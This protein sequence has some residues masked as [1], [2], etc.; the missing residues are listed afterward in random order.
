[1]TALPLHHKNKKKFSLLLLLNVPN[2][3]DIYSSVTMDTPV[4]CFF[5]S[6]PGF[7]Y[8]YSFYQHTAPGVIIWEPPDIKCLILQ[9]ARQ[10]VSS[11]V[12]S[13]H[14]LTVRFS[15]CF[16]SVAP[17]HSVPNFQPCVDLFRAALTGS[18]RTPLIGQKIEDWIKYHY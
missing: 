12:F 17:G 9:F 2:K 8:L 4:S 10:L 3:P 18:L 14:V 6:Y 5:Y 1:M 13:Q 11:C 16:G 15:E 7:I